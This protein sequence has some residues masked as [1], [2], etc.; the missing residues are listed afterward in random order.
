MRTLTAVLLGL[1]LAPLAASQAPTAVRE[2]QIVV[3]N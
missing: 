3:V 1:A 2:E